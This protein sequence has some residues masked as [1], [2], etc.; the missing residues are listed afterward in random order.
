MNVGEQNPRWISSRYLYMSGVVIRVA[1]SGK[2]IWYE[3][4]DV[5]TR[6][7]DRN[8]LTPNND[9]IRLEI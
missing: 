6:P 8:A 2:D 7:K 9:Q 3:K 1:R 4:V 5:Y